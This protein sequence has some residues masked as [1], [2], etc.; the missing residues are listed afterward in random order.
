MEMVVVPG[1]PRQ[2]DG[3]QALPS[4]LVAG[5]HQQ[6]G[7]A[8]RAQRKLGALVARVLPEVRALLDRAHLAKKVLAEA[9]PEGTGVHAVEA[10]VVAGAGTGVTVVEAHLGE[11][12][13]VLLAEEERVLV[14]GVEVPLHAR[15]WGSLDCTQTQPRAI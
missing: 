10:G 11:E 5:A 4:A 7:P 13:G 12:A 1:P 15:F 14:V 3:A 6:R 2:Q 8:A 9:R